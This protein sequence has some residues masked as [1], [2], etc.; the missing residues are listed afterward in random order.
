M[1]KKI[2][3][4]IVVAAT[5]LLLVIAGQPA[6]FAVERTLTIQAP[7]ELVIGHIQ[8]LRAMDAWSPWARMDPRMK[9]VY[10]GPEAGVGARSA[11]EGPEI[12]SGRLEV[13]AVAPNREVEMKLEFF[14]PMQATNR[15][16]FLLDEGAEGTA[17]TWRM[18][19]ERDFLGKAVALIMDMD[20]MVG[21]EFAKGLASLETRVQAQVAR[22]R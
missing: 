12:G 8:N 10:D 19:G 14:E 5:I 1:G 2:L 6:S 11:W 21:G 9:I 7:P 17:V 13:T 3:Y 20:T 4:G 18:E 15:V 22:R 16:R